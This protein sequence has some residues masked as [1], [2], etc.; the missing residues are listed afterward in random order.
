MA[1]RRHS[2]PVP[3]KQIRQARK[4]PNIA[5]QL[6][7]AINSR[8]SHILRDCAQPF[9]LD[10]ALPEKFNELPSEYLFADS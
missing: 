3:R 9:F 10:A 5:Q 7:V 4:R 8:C 6:T 2:A 1:L